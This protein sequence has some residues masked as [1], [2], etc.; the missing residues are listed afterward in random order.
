MSL[1]EATGIVKR[2]GATTALA[3]VN[4]TLQAGQVHALLGANGSGKSTLSKVIAGSVAPDQGLITLNGEALKVRSPLEARKAGIAVVYQELSLV[5]DMSVQDNIWLGHELPSNKLM[6][7]KT[8][9]LL[10]KISGV[11]SPTVTPTALVSTLSPDE[12][13]LVEFLKA[14]SLEP[15]IL[16]LDESTASLDAKQVDRLFAL[17]NELRSSGLGIVIVT[18]RMAE[19]ERIADSVTVLRNGTLVAC[20]S[21]QD[22]SREQLVSLITGEAGSALRQEK[23][24]KAA[25]AARLEVNLKQVAQIKNVAFTLC[26]GEILGLGGLQGQG[27]SELLLALFGALPIESGEVLQEGKPVRFRHP[28]EAM[29]A[30]LAYVPGDRNREGLLGSRSIFENTLLPAWQTHSYFFGLKIPMARAAALEIGKRLKLKFGVLEDQITSL[31]GGNAQK[32]VIGKWLL[33]SPQ[34]L[35]LD[36]PTKGIDVGAKAEFYY[37]LSELR[38]AGISIIFNSSDEDELLSLCDRVLVM[39]EGGIA[40]ELTGAALTRANLIRTSLGAAA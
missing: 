3:G 15:Q 16:I 26:A 37:L 7:A 5:P 23:N 33:R 28:Q 12:R 38:A 6:C 22:T 36:D 14:L 9:E 34:I 18:H 10:E 21:L 40:A 19:I 20:S 35:L 8:V 2:Y 4:F 24:T 31:S 25:G 29:Q 27:Q 39:L 30:G 17:V 13:Q 11:V 32:V 1:L